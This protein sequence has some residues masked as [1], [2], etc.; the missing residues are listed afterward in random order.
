[1]SRYGNTNIKNNIIKRGIKDKKS[2]QIQSNFT[3]LYD[4]IPESERDLHLITQEGDRLDLLANQYYGD[5]R[6]WW[7]IAKANNLKF[8]TVERGTK[9][10]IPFQTT[11]ARGS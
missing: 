10:R 11:R 9:I 4:S 5:P 3:T 2:Y 7:Y 8:I 6:L 1:M